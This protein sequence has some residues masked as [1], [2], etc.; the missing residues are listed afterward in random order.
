M[1]ALLALFMLW[2]LARAR[3][4]DRPP[5]PNPVTPLLSQL[6]PRLRFE[7]LANRLSEVRPRIEAA[8]Q[9]VNGRTVLRVNDGV[10]VAFAD[11]RSLDRGES[12]LAIDRASGV[13]LVETITGTTAGFRAWEPERLDQPRYLVTAR[14]SG[15]R[16]QLAP[17][18]FPELDPV[19]SP[20]W[21]GMVWAVSKETALAP[22]AFVFTEDAHLVGL[23]WTDGVTVAIIPAA[24]LLAETGR[25]LEA[26]SDVPGW[27][28]IEVASLSPSLSRATGASTGVVVTRVDSRS[29]SF[30]VL[31]IGDVIERADS[32]GLRSPLEWA[33]VER[34]LIAGKSLHIRVVRQGQ[35]LDVFATPIPPP[36]QDASARLGL[37]M[38]RV[39][40]GTEVLHVEA[41]S[42]AAMAGLRNGD[43]IVQA[44]SVSAPGPD[45]VRSLFAARQEREALLIAVSRDG[46]HLLL[47]LERDA[48]NRP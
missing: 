46:I 1:A 45:R 19:S 18:F 13:G 6:T 39:R 22:G 41:D 38:R 28:G 25:I 20:L 5:S 8:V 15:G 10:A 11:P 36:H 43:V 29:P 32:H 3:F 16:I 31:S 17:L 48:T 33:A 47:T 14:A 9:A 40:G 27:L 35:H 23:A 30:P 37:E 21:P 7:D 42:A 26:R 34:R 2:A 12:F 24:S 44:G 4:P